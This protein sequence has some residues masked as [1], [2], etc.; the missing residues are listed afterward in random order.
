MAAFHHPR[1]RPRR[2]HLRGGPRLRRLHHPRLAGHQRVGHAR[3][4]RP[5]DGVPRP[6]LQGHDADHDLQH[7]GSA[8]QGRLHPRSPQRRPQGRQLHEVDRHRR[9]GLLRPGAGVLRLRQTSATIRPS[10]PATTS[11]TA[12]KAPG[13]PAGDPTKGPQ[14]NL[15]YKLRYKEGY[16][17]VPPVRRAARHPHA[18]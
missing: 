15:G 16:F 10:T 8:H 5:G 14:P 18:R 11:S 4:A 17:P 9:H 13:T 2:K 12:A 6:V 1:R 7:P 3:H